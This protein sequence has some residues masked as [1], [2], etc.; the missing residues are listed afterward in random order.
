MHRIIPSKEIGLSSMHNLIINKSIKGIIILIM[1]IES[2][3]VYIALLYVVVYFDS[4]TFLPQ[5]LPERNILVWGVYRQFQH[6]S[7]GAR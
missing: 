1:I 6:K 3:W 5:I 4:F 7:A 2:A